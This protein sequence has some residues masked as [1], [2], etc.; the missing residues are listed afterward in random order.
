MTVL[1]RA[2]HTGAVLVCQWLQLQADAYSHLKVARSPLRT[3][4][5]SSKYGVSV[6]LIPGAL[7]SGISP[8]SR[9]TW[10]STT[11]HDS[12]PQALTCAYLHSIIYFAACFAV[13][14]MADLLA[15]AEHVLMR[16]RGLGQPVLSNLGL[17]SSNY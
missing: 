9:R 17:H 3:A 12:S 13:C 14:F 11:A 6:S 2:Q 4:H 16:C 15:A 10:G 5:V 7:N 8:S 1:P